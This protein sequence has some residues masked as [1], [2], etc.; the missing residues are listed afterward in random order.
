MGIAYTK[1]KVTGRIEGRWVRDQLFTDPLCLA[2]IAMMK[3]LIGPTMRDQWIPA[4]ETAKAGA[5][6]KGK[7]MSSETLDA[8]K[9]IER[10]QAAELKMPRAMRKKFGL[11]TCPAGIYFPFAD[12]IETVLDKAYDAVKDDLPVTYD[13]YQQVAG[14]LENVCPGDPVLM[15][16]ALSQFAFE[17]RYSPANVGRGKPL[18]LSADDRA[19]LAHYNELRG[20][21]GLSPVES[22]PH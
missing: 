16:S 1:S 12:R 19:E 4:N 6:G 2:G 18:A 9:A 10:R 15:Q 3:P 11:V 7:N 8:G 22:L 21:A 20:Y 5:S 14:A 17:V 13:Q